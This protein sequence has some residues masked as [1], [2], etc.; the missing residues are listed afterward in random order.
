VSERD[1]EPAT[2]RAPES[3]RSPDSALSLA[4]AGWLRP[5]GYADGIVATGRILVTSGQIGWDPL[6]QR[7]VAGGFTAQT[8]QAL[9]NVVAVLRAGGGEPEHLVRLTWYVT[10]RQAYLDARVDIGRAYRE[11]IG[12]HYPAMAIVIVAGLVEADAMVEIEAT[13]VL[14]S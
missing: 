8:R 9:A 10:D 11:T 3:L 2:S 12:R 7:I 5:S 4:P 13:A 14:P 6:T 1:V